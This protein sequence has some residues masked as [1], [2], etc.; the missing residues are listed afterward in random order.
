MISNLTHAVDIDR[1]GSLRIVVAG[2][3]H[4]T[5]R[6]VWLLLC[7]Y[8]MLPQSS[9]VP[10]RKAGIK[11]TNNEIFFDVI[12]EIDC[13]IDSNGQIV[14]SEISGRVWTTVSTGVGFFT[15]EVTRGLRKHQE[16]F[17]KGCRKLA[18]GP[19]GGLETMCF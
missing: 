8:L 10:W 14:S 15:R 12:E 7:P 17:L 5:G 9:P 6:G 18:S 16:I 2:K 13:I 19:E 3:V 11:Y 1:D 4:S